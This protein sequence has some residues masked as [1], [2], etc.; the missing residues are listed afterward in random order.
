MI[1]ITKERS[2]K[3]NVA[4]TY[5]T[6]EGGGGGERWRIE[7]EPKNNRERNPNQTLL[8]LNIPNT[9]SDCTRKGKK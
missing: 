6:Y 8:L 7:L 2:V 5:R 1:T 3:R 4:K 9:K